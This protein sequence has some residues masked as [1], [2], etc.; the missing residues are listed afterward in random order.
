MEFKIEVTYTTYMRV[1]FD[2]KF[3]IKLGGYTLND[4]FAVTTNCMRK[5]NF[6]HADIMDDNTGEV[7]AI[8]NSE[9]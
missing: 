4:A 6:T 8:V 7:L 3:E 9:Q 5:H 2:D 1:L